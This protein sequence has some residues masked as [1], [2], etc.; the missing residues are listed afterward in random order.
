VTIG[1]I[2]GAMVD[3]Q[4]PTVPTTGEHGRGIID[5]GAE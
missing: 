5:L 3:F 1:T 4:T 2:K